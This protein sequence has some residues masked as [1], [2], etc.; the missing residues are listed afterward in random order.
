MA[1][2]V[3]LTPKL[4]PIYA[5]SP[6]SYITSLHALKTRARLVTGETLLVLGASGGVGSTAI[7]IGKIL[8]ATVIACASTQKKL[9]VC[10]KFGADYVINYLD[11]ARDEGTNKV[12][13]NTSVIQQ[14]PPHATMLGLHLLMGTWGEEGVR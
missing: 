12:S 4:D 5:P 10:K 7:Q 1:A 13:G 14:P 3:K 11:H 8:G 6:Y 9:D 2:M